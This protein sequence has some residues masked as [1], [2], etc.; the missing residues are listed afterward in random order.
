MFNCLLTKCLVT[1]SC[2][3]CSLSFALP[4]RC[5]NIRAVHA[6]RSKSDRWPCHVTLTA[7]RP[8]N[9]LSRVFSTYILGQKVDILTHAT[10]SRFRFLLILNSFFDHIAVVEQFFCLDLGQK[11]DLLRNAT[12]SRCHILGQKVDLLRN[13]TTSRCPLW[14]KKLTFYGM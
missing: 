5:N 14:A 7:K 3:L 13:V 10:L 9:T 2:C 1:H 11:V 8:K 6:Y 12:T 4:F